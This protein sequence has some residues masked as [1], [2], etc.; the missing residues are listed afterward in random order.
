MKNSVKKIMAL[1]A[2][3]LSAAMCIG[4][5]AA[6]NKG[7]DAVHT[8]AQA[9][10]C[11][12]AGNTEYWVKGG[13]Y[14]SDE[15]CA[16]EIA[17]SATVIAALGHDFDNATYV[18]TDDT[19]HWKVCAREG[20][21]E[22]TTKAD[23]DFT[24]GDCVCGKVTPP[25]NHVAAQTPTCKDA[26]NIEYWVKGGRYYSDAACTAEIT[27]EQTVI[28]KTGNH[29]PAAE[30]TKEEYKHY[31]ACT[32][33]GDPADAKADHTFTDGECTVCHKTNGFENI[34]LD[35]S[36]TISQA[37][38]EDTA[39]SVKINIQ[40]NGTDEWSVKLEYK[41]NGLE[42]GDAFVVKYAV[43]SSKAGDI[44][45]ETYDDSLNNDNNLKLKEGVQ[46]VTAYGVVRTQG[47]VTS[48]L[49]LGKLP[50]GSVL[51]FT[52]VT[53][54]KITGHGMIS[55]FTKPGDSVVNYTKSENADGSVKV[56]ATAGD[57]TDWHLKLEQRLDFENGKTYDMVY[58]VKFNAA[59][60]G[61]NIRLEIGD[62]AADFTGGNEFYWYDKGA[63]TLTVR[64]R[65][66][67]VKNASNV[68]C[69]LLLGQLA[70]A[71][72]AIDLDFIYGG[73]IEVA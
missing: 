23:H 11:T 49:K 13:K 57:G 72:N 9:A 4:S 12:V 24:S 18:S 8:A 3:V 44:Y 54:E 39:T 26:G 2:C 61:N 53:C 48:V 27:Q 31:H 51:E 10:T 5:F 30:Y 47:E 70:G 67:A 52:S 35:V 29:T 60:S 37:T 40:Q 21:N 64:Y 59:L 6:C 16:N 42:A 41:L 15:A 17:Q 65:F 71:S 46:V 32:V 63:D 45:F 25:P 1:S 66:T 14:Y 28:A 19:Q 38:R 58:V 22:T 62:S 50:D 20:C 7:D 33:C 55:T 73:L 43:T 56:A 34:R 36:E 69:C 68:Y